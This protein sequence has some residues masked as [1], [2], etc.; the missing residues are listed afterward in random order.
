MS[1][2]SAAAELSRLSAAQLEAIRSEVRS[3]D[4]FEAH[5]SHFPILGLCAAC[6]GKPAG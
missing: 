6:A 5:F 4:G 3:A 1:S 2:A